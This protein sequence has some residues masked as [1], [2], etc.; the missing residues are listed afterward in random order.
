[1]AQLQR[2]AISA[3]Q[4][5]GRQIQLTASQQHYLCRVLRLD[6]GEQF[7][8]IDGQGQWWLAALQTGG[9]TAEVL[10]A[11]AVNTELPIALTLLMA[12]PKTGMDDV[13]RQST[14]IGVQQ[15][16][17]ILSQRTVLKPSPQKLDRWRRIAQEAAEQSERQVVPEILVPQSWTAALQTWNAVMGR[18]YLCEARGNHPH[19][20]HCLTTTQFPGASLLLAIG[21]EG[22][23]ADAE[24]EQALAVGYQPVSLGAR[25]LR[26]VT[27]PLV[28]LSLLAAVIET[29]AMREG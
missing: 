3:T 5:S 19:L 18:A 6:Q 27:A 20:L 14:E 24:I 26:S 17:P 7:I 23:W 13:V 15:I 8:A 25:I 2:L 16:V 1:M 12:L 10:E 22:G 28:A 21:P 9:L 29:Q 11:V 4:L